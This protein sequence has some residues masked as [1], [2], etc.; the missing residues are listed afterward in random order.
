MEILGVRLK[1]CF[2]KMSSSTHFFTFVPRRVHDIVGDVLNSV[3]TF[4][5]QH[6]IFGSMKYGCKC[7]VLM[8]TNVWAHNNACVFPFKWK[9]V[10]YSEYLTGS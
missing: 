4:D 5:N 10:S 3:F 7:A 1:S 2:S 9:G 8:L 6:L